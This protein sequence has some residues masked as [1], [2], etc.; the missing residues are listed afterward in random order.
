[1]KYTLS[2]KLNN[3]YKKS[4]LSLIKKHYEMLNNFE[5]NAFDRIWKSEV[6]KKDYNNCLDLL[7]RTLKKDGRI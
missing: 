5:K 2:N 3:I 4:A 6:P 7:E 1:M